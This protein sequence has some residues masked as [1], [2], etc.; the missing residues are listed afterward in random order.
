MNRFAICL[1]ILLLFALNC[2]SQDFIHLEK[3]KA[4]NKLEKYR[5]V[6]KNL[7][8]DIKET[9]SSLTFLL[10]DSSIRPL[11]IILVF[12]KNGKC[13][14]ETHIWNCDSC[15]Q[16]YKNKVL[17]DKHYQWNKITASLYVSKF[18]KGMYM[19]A[20]AANLHT[21]V[22]RRFDFSRKEYMEYYGNY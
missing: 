6:R 18:S 21:L 8:T 20:S 17:D 19:D 16:K 9:D 5:E 12:D 4:R 11:D 3:G 7:N 14:T 13:K 2:Y 15:L 1:S 10:R 22:F